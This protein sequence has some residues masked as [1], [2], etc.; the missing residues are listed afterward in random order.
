[1]LHKTKKRIEA[2]ER[3]ISRLETELKRKATFQTFEYGEVDTEWL[4]QVV[5]KHIKEAAGKGGGGSG[6]DAIKKES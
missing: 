2:L 3:K 6:E 4:A 5:A 1:M